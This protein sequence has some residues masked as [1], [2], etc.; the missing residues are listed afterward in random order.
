MNNNRKSIILTVVFVLFLIGEVV[1][2]N[3]KID[4]ICHPVEH[5]TVFTTEDCGSIEQKIAILPNSALDTTKSTT[6]LNNAKEFNDSTKI[7]GVKNFLDAVDTY[8]NDVIILIF[9]CFL[10][11]FAIL[12]LVIKFLPVVNDQKK[13]QT[14]INT[15]M[16]LIIISIIVLICFISDSSWAYLA[17]VIL[18]ILYLNQYKE[19]L[20]QNFS[21]IAA[22]LQGK[23]SITYPTQ[24]EMSD[25]RKTEAI[26]NS[27]NANQQAH[28]R[29][30][31]VMGRN[32]NRHEIHLINRQVAEYTAVEQLAI[33]HLQQ[34]YP[35]F[36]GPIK[37]R[38]D[39]NQRV[40]LDGLIQNENKNIV[41]EIKYCQN[42]NLNTRKLKPL[43]EVTDYIT[44]KTGIST[45]L[46]LFI[47][48]D[49][50]PLKHKLETK[51]Q[52]Q[53][54][55]GMNLQVQVYTREELN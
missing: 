1:A 52:E 20:L 10:I 42:E 25:K 26:E 22:A 35:N 38:M 32:I 28:P 24:Q 46:L 36:Q 8:K 48:V 2:C 40:V 3:N 7:S 13:R 30:V 49:Q 37:L 6:I 34:E 44:K 31:G 9:L 51:Y 50:E 21:T 16:Q 15:L 19:G 5:V 11:L 23:L 29:P 39:A 18:C 53:L 27:V 55:D 41:V 12:L 17:L 47:V 54:F 45:M 14:I 33:N 4:T 43:F